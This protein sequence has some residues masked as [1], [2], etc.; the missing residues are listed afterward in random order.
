MPQ[1]VIKR[2]KRKELYDPKKVILTLQKIGLNDEEIEEI[3]K[4]INIYLPSVVTTQELFKFIFHFLKNKQHPF[5]Y[6]LNLK[7]A[8]ARLGPTGYPFEKFIS[9]LLRFYG[10]ETRHNL[11]LKGSCLSYEIDFEAKIEDVRYLGEC[12]FHSDLRKKND[13]KTVLYSYAR[14]LDLQKTLGDKIHLWVV[15]NTRFTQEAIKFSKCYN[16]RLLSWDFP[17]GES[18][19]DLI[20]RKKL[21]PLSI[22]DFLSDSVLQK[23]FSYDLVLITDVAQ[24]SPSYLKK[25][26]GLEDKEITKLLEFCSIYA[27][28]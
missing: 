7:N 2:D 21:Y 25:I 18:L 15:T 11:Y 28:I 6:R 13:V 8:L 27:K 23:F 10:Y 9:H 3:L 19:K 5:T 1:Y 16:F 26:S 24:K 14:F 17:P 22:F 12:K 4:E 20:E